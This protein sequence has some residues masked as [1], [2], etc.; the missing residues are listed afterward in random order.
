MNDVIGL[1]EFVKRQVKGSRFSYYDGTFDE[2]VKLC[3]DEFKTTENLSG[4]DGVVLLDVPADKFYSGLVEI[5]DT[6][7]LQASFIKRQ[8]NEA[9]YINVNAVDE[10]FTPA[11]SVTIV[12]YTYDRL[13]LNNEQSTECEMEIICINANPTVES[14]P[15]TPLTMAR[16]FLDLEGGTKSVYT[17]EEFAKAIVYWSNHAMVN[18]PL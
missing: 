6:T 1:N 15:M 7:T 17:A 10:E 9:P 11:K 18:T 13:R 12:L 5:T 2:L 3:N 14:T 8:E 4:G 16:N